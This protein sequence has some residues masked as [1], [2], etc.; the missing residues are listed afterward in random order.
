[1]RCLGFAV[2][3]LVLLSTLSCAQEEVYVG[4]Y[5]LDVSNYDIRSGEF[6][7]DFYLDLYCDYN[8]SPGKFEFMNGR[9]TKID[10]IIDEPDEQFYRIQGVF[11]SPVNMEKYPFDSQN[12]TIVMEDKL[13]TTENLTYLV[14]KNESG[15]DEAIVFNGWDIKEWDVNV[16]EHYYPPWDETFSRYTYSVKIERIT[17]NALLKTFVPL[18][19]IIII[20]LASLYLDPKEMG[21]RLTIGGSTLITTVLLHL[22]ILSEIP[23]TPYLTFTDKFMFVT[24]FIML[25]SFLANIFIL[26]LKERNRHQLIHKVQMLTERL[27][28][29]VPVVYILL[30]LLLLK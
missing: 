17:L 13:K 7:A 9:A 5:L 22:S 8:C 29:F 10:K 2:L 15:I 27:V 21:F 24:Y 28:L 16:D 4:L 25:L 26:E 23:P 1:M 12:I 3:L 14:V 6:T 19:S 30:F 11:Y 20:T 18:F